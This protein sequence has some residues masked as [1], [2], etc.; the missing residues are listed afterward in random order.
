MIDIESLVKQGL[1]AEVSTA[2][3]LAGGQRPGGEIPSLKKINDR[4]LLSITL[5][6]LKNY[7][8][9]KVVICAGPNE[10]KIKK[11]FGNGANLGISIIYSSEDKPLGTA[12]TIKKA[13]KYLSNESF[14]VINDSTLTNLNL[15]DLF[16][17]HLNEETVATI[18]VKPR[19]SERKYGH[20]FLHGNKIVKFL[21]ATTT[22]GISI[23]NVGLYVLK[24]EILQ[25]IPKNQY[26]NFETDIFPKLAEKKELSA[27]VFQG[28][29]FDVSLEDSYKQA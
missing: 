20:A 11:E 27:F 2:V 17:F 8:V 18:C 29:W 3:I 19:M 1:S 21:D 4:P 24:P 9:T 12:G 13:Q 6:H 15:E 25:T 22:Q 28:S 5:E 14:L 23:V 16:N 7:G 10:A 26:L